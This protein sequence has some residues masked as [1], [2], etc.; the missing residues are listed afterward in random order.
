MKKPITIAAVGAMQLLAGGTATYRLAE[1][2]GTRASVVANFRLVIQG[3]WVHLNAVKASGDRFE[4][5]VKSAAYP[6]AELEQARRQVSRYILR[7]GSSAAREYRNPVT[8]GAVLLSSGG[9]EHLLPKPGAERFPEKVRLLG[10]SY[11]RES[12]PPE[13]RVELPA[14]I[15][16][17]QLRPDLLVGPAHNFQTRDN[18]RRWDGSDYEYVRLM[19]SD[20]REMAEAGI[21]CVNAD[22][23]QVEWAE[24]LGLFYSGG[25]AEL[26]YPELLYRTQYLGPAIF[27]DEPAVGTR[28][29]VLR[30]AL[31]RNPG[32]R[33]A[34]TP[35]IA[36]GAFEKSYARALR[37]GPPTRLMQML[38]SRT[39]VDPGDMRFVLPN[40][41]NWDTMVATAAYQLLRDRRVPS[42]IVF[43]APGRIGTRRTVPEMAM[44]YGVRMRPDD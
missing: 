32:F 26:P 36:F 41:F 11:I 12:F 38:A 5:W 31:A 28:D 29:H 6:A 1:G 7:E 2:A 19:R 16:V 24:E 9:W 42:A 35:Q 30:P 27:L 33:K 23:E 3:D 34:I 10:H 21:T 17:V 44:S 37:E 43:E 15:G 25:G 4:V 13:D 14:D 39:D 8:G 22:G 20:Y 40:L 18:R